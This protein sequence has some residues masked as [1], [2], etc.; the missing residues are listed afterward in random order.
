MSCETSVV[1][2]DG[3]VGPLTTLISQRQSGRAPESNLKN[4]GKVNGA[5][6]LCRSG[7]QDPRDLL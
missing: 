7:S 5:I 6:K 3:L 1:T 2:Y 4:S